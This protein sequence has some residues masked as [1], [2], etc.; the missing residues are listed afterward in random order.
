[1]VD[2][3]RGKMCME[4][5]IGVTSRLDALICMRYIVLASLHRTLS[6]PTGP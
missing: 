2:L 6:V 5:D 1:M 3:S 4:G